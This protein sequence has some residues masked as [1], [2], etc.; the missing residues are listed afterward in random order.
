MRQFAGYEELRTFLKSRTFHQIEAYREA[1][2]AFM[3]S[4]AFL[5]FSKTTFTDRLAR[6]VEEDTGV[7]LRLA[8]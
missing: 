4:P 2:R 3:T 8:A 5:P 7:S 6:I 1:A